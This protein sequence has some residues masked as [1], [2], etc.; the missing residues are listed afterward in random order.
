MDV[1]DERN[2]NAAPDR[3]EAL[4]GLHVRHSGADDFAA[5]LLK[6]K[7]LRD[8]RGDVARVGFGHGLHRNRRVPADGDL[9]DLNLPCLVS[10]NHNAAS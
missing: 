4:R 9:P 7:N 5:R 3:A 2:V 6:L 10:L 1:R 8:R